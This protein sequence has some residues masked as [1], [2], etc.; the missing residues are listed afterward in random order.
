[1]LRVAWLDVTMRTDP[2][3]TLGTGMACAC[4]SDLGHGI[5]DTTTSIFLEGW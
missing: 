5:S 4:E 3:P 2:R 1:M